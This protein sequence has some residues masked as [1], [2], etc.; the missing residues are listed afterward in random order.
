MKYILLLLLLAGG[1]A[2]C[3]QPKIGY[4]KTDQAEYLIDTLV[5]YRTLDPERNYIEE[6]ML[7]SGT[8]WW[9]SN[10]ISGVLGTVPIVYTIE[11]VKAL[12]GGDA[13]AFLKEVKIIGGGRLY[14][15]VNDI[16]APNGTYLISV[17]VSN[18]DHSAVLEDA[19]RIII[20][21]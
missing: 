6:N 13:A 10:E 5:V 1:I 8:E 19:F 17:R 18:D 16:K 4:L 7:E 15:P 2:A 14:Y 12:D 3:N 9:A 21:D 20:K 11:D